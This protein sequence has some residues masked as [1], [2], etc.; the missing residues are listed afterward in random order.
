MLPDEVEKPM[1]AVIALMEPD[2]IAE[3]ELND[4]Y[5]NEHI[6][7]RMEVAGCLAVQRFVCT[8]GWPRYLALFDWDSLDALSGPAYKAVHDA[9]K[10]TPWTVRILTRI[11]G[12]IRKQA[13]QV[14]PGRAKL[15]DKGALARVVLARITGAPDTKSD[16]LVAALSKNFQH[17]PEVLQ[18]RLFRT[19]GDTTMRAQE[20]WLVVE[21]GS[22]VTG[23][24]SGLK[25]L[26]LKP[27]SIDLINVYSKYWR[28]LT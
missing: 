7:Q 9:S 6:P 18:W 3:D 24:T 10:R 11:R 22:I 4:W 13:V 23:D 16:S 2:T 17:A 27:A 1:A 15:G 19:D 20:Y 5:D 12:W 28:L 26:S 25:N 8:D 21:Y 14:H